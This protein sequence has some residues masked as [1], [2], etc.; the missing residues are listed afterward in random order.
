[1]ADHTD[2]INLDNIVFDDQN[3]EKRSWSCLGQTCS[4][5]LIVLLTEFFVIL[6]IFC[7]IN[8]PRLLTN[9]QFGWE[10]CAMQQD[11]FYLYQSYER[12]SF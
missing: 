5:S 9:L 7:V 3:V 1:M 11:T 12:D 2:N 4:K 6:L 8:W 10:S